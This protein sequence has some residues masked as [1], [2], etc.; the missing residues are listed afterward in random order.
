MR[1]NYIH[2]EYCGFNVNSFINLM[3]AQYFRN[4][5]HQQVAF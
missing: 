1:L 4:R 5:T 3:C 2:S